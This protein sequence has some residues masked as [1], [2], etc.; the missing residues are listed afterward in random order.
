M[1]TPM[2]RLDAL[3][4]QRSQLPPTQRVD[5]VVLD[6]RI[7][8]IEGTQSFSAISSTEVAGIEFRSSVLNSSSRMVNR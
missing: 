1:I 6:Q 4:L 3:F 8:L 5:D 7:K 2:N